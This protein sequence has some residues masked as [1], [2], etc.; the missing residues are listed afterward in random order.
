M[1]QIIQ[2]TISKHRK[3]IWSSQFGLLKTRIGLTNMIAF[4]SKTS[5]VDENGAVDDIYLDFIKAFD[6]VSSNVLMKK[7]MKHRL[8]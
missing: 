7:W 5:S 6:R 8:C 1:E 3:M 4:Y 2:E